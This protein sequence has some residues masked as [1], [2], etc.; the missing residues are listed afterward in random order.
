MIEEDI[1]A[2]PEQTSDIDIP[3]NGTRFQSIHF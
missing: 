2:P 1:A 3:A